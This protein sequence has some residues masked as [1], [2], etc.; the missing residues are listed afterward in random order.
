M[1]SRISRVSWS[2]ERRVGLGAEKVWLKKVEPFGVGEVSKVCCS[3]ARYPT[4]PTSQNP[5]LGQ[6]LKGFC[7]RVA[8]LLGVE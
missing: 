5:F 2:R 8:K 1:A 6:S 3:H 7:L 4:E